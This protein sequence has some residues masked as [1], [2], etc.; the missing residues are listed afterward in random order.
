MIQK[1]VPRG[2]TAVATMLVILVALAV[3]AGGWAVWQ[4][5]KKQEPAKSSQSLPAQTTGKTNTQ[6]AQADPSENGNYLVIKEWGVRI[7]LPESLRGEVI[8][9]IE[10]SLEDSGRETA[11]FAV[12]SLA[13]VPG[14]SCKLTDSTAPGTTG[15]R[16]GIGVFLIRTVEKIPAG[17]SAYY[18][19]PATN[20]HIENHWFTGGREKYSEACINDESKLQL[21]GD[22]ILSLVYS[23]EKVGP[24][25]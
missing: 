24:M 14:S 17:Q 7:I 20:M 8:Y 5:N 2:F 19:A 13:S 1:L 11:W 22:T 3:G 15:K 12:T 6:S 21:T 23:L 9:G 18:Y 25:P 10:Q 4:K 16:G